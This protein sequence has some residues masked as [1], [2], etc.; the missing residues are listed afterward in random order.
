MVDFS[1]AHSVYSLQAMQ[2]SQASLL[3]ERSHYLFR[4]SLTT[5]SRYS[6]HN[7]N[8]NYG[9]RDCAF[10]TPGFSPDP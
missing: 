7:S 4:F 9:L 6:R 8:P 5:F 3:A 1:R 2:L 10:R